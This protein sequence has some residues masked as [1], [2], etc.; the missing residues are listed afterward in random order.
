MDEKNQETGETKKC[1]FCGETILACAR[2]CRFCGEMLDASPKSS[3][4]GAGTGRESSFWGWKSNCRSLCRMAILGLALVGA[5]VFFVVMHSDSE[6]D[7]IIDSVRNI[8]VPTKPPISIGCRNSI[9]RIWSSKP[10]I[11]IL[12]TNMDGTKG[13]TGSI[14]KHVGSS[15][16]GG[17]RFILGVGEQCKEFGSLQLAQPFYDGDEGLVQIDGYNNGLYFEVNK[18]LTGSWRF[19]FLP[20]AL[21]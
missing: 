16:T 13:L 6:G 2:K 18:N 21:R 4:S 17:E 8:V 14:W 11:V 7:D 5:I 3:G 10:S 9:S 12:I 19:D 1:P 15:Y 20:K